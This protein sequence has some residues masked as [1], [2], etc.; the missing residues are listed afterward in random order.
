LVAIPRARETGCRTFAV[1]HVNGPGDAGYCRVN[2]GRPEKFSLSVAFTIENAEA[3][4]LSFILAA[5]IPIFFWWRYTRFWPQEKLAL[6]GA[7]PNPRDTDAWV[8][9]KMFWHDL[10]PH[11]TNTNEQDTA[12]LNHLCRRCN[13]GIVLV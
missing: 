9:F 2:F 6:A 8:N 10:T 13:P 12:G 3:R 5:T 11:S 7:I 1:N 4:G